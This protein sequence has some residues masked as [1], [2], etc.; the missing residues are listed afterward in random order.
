MVCECVHVQ[1]GYLRMCVFGRQGGES[2]C[3][4]LYVQG[5]LR[6]IL[7]GHYQLST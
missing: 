4:V 6:N 3:T 7:L 1:Y 2:I 5:A